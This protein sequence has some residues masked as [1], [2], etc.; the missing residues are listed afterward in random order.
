MNEFKTL[1]THQCTPESQSVSV[2]A[3]HTIMEVQR[4]RDSNRKT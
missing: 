2:E 4:T 3:L 1:L